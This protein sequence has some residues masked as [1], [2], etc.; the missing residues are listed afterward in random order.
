MKIRAA[1]Q[2]CF[3]VFLLLTSSASVFGYGSSGGSKPCKP[4]T[5]SNQTPPKSSVVLPGAPFSLIVSKAR[6]SSIAVTVK[7]IPVDV[8]VTKQKNGQL[9]VEGHIP[10][11]L[12]DTHARIQVSAK[13]DSGCAK[14]DGWLIKVGGASE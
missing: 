14:S 10:P 2:Q 12:R 6:P 11:T 13:T 8:S 4:P 7:R 5:F 9:L 3:F 1:T